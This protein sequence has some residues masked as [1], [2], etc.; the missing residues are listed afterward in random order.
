MTID[1]YMHMIMT[2]ENEHENW[3]ADGNEHTHDNEIEMESV[4]KL[5]SKP[6]KEKVKYDAQQLN[7]MK[8]TTRGVL[9]I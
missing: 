9:P 5:L 4:P 1:M 8:K 7:Y 6:L 2:I 3:N